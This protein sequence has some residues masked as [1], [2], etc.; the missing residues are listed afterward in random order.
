MSGGH[1]GHLAFSPHPTTEPSAPLVQTDLIL[2]PGRLTALLGPWA[3]SCRHSKPPS[4][5]CQLGRCERSLV[6][7][8]PS[9][10]LGCPGT[11]GMCS[12][13][14]QCPEPPQ[15]C[16]SFSPAPSCLPGAPSVQAGLLPSWTHHPALFFM[17]FR[18]PRVAQLDTSENGHHPEPGS[19]S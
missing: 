19:C 1:L 5:G 12:I 8:S 18:I 3:P 15:L 17:T 16:P 9:S 11:L 4:W 6:V 10:C 2:L 7:P 14:Q 13:L